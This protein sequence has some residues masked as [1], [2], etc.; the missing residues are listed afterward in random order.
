[1]KYLN[2][3]LGGYKNY[4]SVKNSSITAII[5]QCDIYS[6]LILQDIPINAID[7]VR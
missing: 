7:I 5:T 6:Y 1:M 3:K 2:I 4:L